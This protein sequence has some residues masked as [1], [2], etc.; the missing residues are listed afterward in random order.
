MIFLLFPS[1]GGDVIRQAFERGAV[2]PRAS[3]AS[4][5]RV[6]PQ[7]CYS[8][9]LEFWARDFSAFQFLPQS[10]GDMILLLASERLYEVNVL[11]Q[12]RVTGLLGTQ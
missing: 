2:W 11:I 9:A 1:V 12:E 4:L 3:G 6:G 8:Q 10:N 7:P 5:P